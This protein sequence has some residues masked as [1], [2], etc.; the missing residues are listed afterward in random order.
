[1]RM[2]LLVNDFVYRAVNDSAVIL[3]EAHFKRNYLHVRDV[4]RVF[5]H[6]LT[7]YESLKGLPYNVGLSD[8][9]LSK[10]E[11]CE[12]I[13]SFLPKFVFMEA[14]IGEDPDKRDYIVSNERIEKTGWRPKFSVSDGIQELIKAYRIIHQNQYK[15]I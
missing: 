15:N 10:R 7:N 9:N 1:M 14:T 8:V 4:A 11:L 6:G 2:D 5:S 13:C 3:F 12:L